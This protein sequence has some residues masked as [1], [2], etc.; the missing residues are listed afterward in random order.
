MRGRHSLLGS[1]NGPVHVVGAESLAAL[2][3]YPMAAITSKTKR[4]AR[5]SRQT[6][7]NL[8]NCQHAILPPAERGA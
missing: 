6:V 7:S 8:C 3:L 1:E 5:M 2:I 4:S